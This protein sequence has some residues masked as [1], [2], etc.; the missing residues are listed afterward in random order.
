MNGRNYSRVDMRGNPY[1]VIG[2]R[3]K[4]NNGF[5]SGFIEIEG[6]LYKITVSNH[7]NK[8]SVTAWCT[9]TQYPKRNNT[10]SF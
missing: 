3:D 1:K 10:S 4:K 5:M 2:L 7:S 9:V 8:E 6:K